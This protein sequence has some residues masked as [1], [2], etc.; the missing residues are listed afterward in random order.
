M[1][2][3]IIKKKFLQLTLNHV[4]I[5]VSIYKE[6][7]NIIFFLHLIPTFTYHRL[8]SFKIVWLVYDV[9][10]PQ[11]FKSAVFVAKGEWVTL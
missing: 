7:V 1:K 10:I 3:F 8:L 2:S 5:H 4:S 9:E 11:D 6:S